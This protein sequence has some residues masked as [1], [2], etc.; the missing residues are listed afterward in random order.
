[1]STNTLENQTAAQQAEKLDIAPSPHIRDSINTRK[2]MLTVCIALVPS[3]AAATYFFGPRALLLTV[4]CVLACMLF[5]QLFCMITKRESTIGDCSAAVTGMILAFNLPATF[6]AWMAIIGCFFAIIIVKNIFG[7]IG[8]NFA[9]P[10]ATARVFLLVSFATQMTNWVMPLSWMKGELVTGATPLNIMSGEGTQALPTLAQMFIGERGG[11]LGETCAIALIIGG[12]FLIWR[13]IISPV[14]P[15]CV[16]G[17]V[18]VFALLFGQDPLYS[19]LSG[20]VMIGAFFMATD[21]ATSPFTTKGQIIFGIGI[22]FLTMVIRQFCS[23]PEG[24]SFA[25]LLMNILTP[26]IDN[27]TMTKPFGAVFEQAKK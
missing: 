5:E 17:S 23:Y 26:H 25:I 12:A 22:G 2:I 27:L 3:L 7:G 24:M 9:N 10:A 14:I 1:M 6:P 8:C 21:Y 13:G 4:I 19:I 15:V 18:A 16:I 11:S 20:G